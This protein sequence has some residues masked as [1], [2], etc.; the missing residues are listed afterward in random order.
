ML[1][2]KIGSRFQIHFGL[3]MLNVSL[4]GEVTVKPET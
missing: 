4:E 3:E 1:C 2:C